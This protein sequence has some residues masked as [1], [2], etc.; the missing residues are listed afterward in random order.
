MGRA[1]AFPY[2]TTSAKQWLRSAC[3]NA[4][5]D[6]SHCFALISQTFKLSLGEYYLYL[7]IFH[8]QCCYSALFDQRL[9]YEQARYN[10]IR[11]TEV[12]WLPHIYFLS[13]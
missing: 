5:A 9:C 7:W 6:Q 13:L 12:N 8:L 11:L 2:K 10:K 4:Q 3:A 1:T